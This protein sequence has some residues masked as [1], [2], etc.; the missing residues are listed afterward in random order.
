MAGLGTAVLVLTRSKCGVFDILKNIS[1]EVL[2]L[3]AG[4]F[5]L[6]EALE[7]TGVTRG[8]SALLQQLVQQSTAMAAWAPAWCSPSAA[9]WSTTF[10]LA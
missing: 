10:P 1:W 3:V 7:K 8:L 9:T 6:V 2:P 4:L 5:V